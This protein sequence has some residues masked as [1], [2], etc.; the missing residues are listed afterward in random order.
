MVSG[1]QLFYAP[2]LGTADVPARISV[3]AS[4]I[5]HFPLP[6]SDLPYSST[7]GDQSTMV[8]AN[9]MSGYLFLFEQIIKTLKS[10][11]VPGV[12]PRS[13]I[14][15]EEL[16]R[17]DT[18]EDCKRSG[19][20]PDASRE[21]VHT[22]VWVLLDHEPAHQLQATME[23]TFTD[24][25]AE[26]NRRKGKRVQQ[27]ISKDNI[28][29]PDDLARALGF[30]RDTDEAFDYIMS[31]SVSNL[32]ETE[33]HLFW[34]LAPP[35]APLPAWV[36]PLQRNPR[37]QVRDG[38]EGI[39]T[40][41]WKSPYP[42]G[43][44]YFLYDFGLKPYCLTPNADVF[45][46]CYYFGIR[47]P[48]DLYRKAIE[49]SFSLCQDVD[50]DIA[51]YQSEDLVKGGS[52]F[53]APQQIKDPAYRRAVFDYGN[54]ADMATLRSEIATPFRVEEVRRYP[55][56]C[57]AL[58]HAVDV[59]S[60]VTSI[61][62]AEDFFDHFSLVADRLFGTKSVCIP[63]MYHNLRTQQ[64]RLNGLFDSMSEARAKCFRS[65]FIG[66]TPYMFENRLDFSWK[67]CF[68][69]NQAQAAV[70]SLVM[71]ASCM[72]VLGDCHLVHIQLNGLHQTGKSHAVRAV[73]ETL[74]EGVVHSQDYAS[75]LAATLGTQERGVL[76]QDETESPNS[77]NDLKVKIL[78][79]LTENGFVSSDR[80]I[81][82]PVT[83]QYEVQRS[84]TLG[85][86]FRL[87]T[88]NFAITDPALKSRYAEIQMPSTEISAFEPNVD[89][90]NDA[91]Y[92]IR[93]F[94]LSS[95]VVP[96]SLH[97]IGTFP[98]TT[99]VVQ[100]FRS[101]LK[102][103]DPLFPMPGVRDWKKIT[104]I[105]TSQ[106]LIR[107][108]L[109]F[110]A[111]RDPK[112]YAKQIGLNAW[113]SASDVVTAF[114]KFTSATNQQYRWTILQA[115]RTMVEI[116]Y[117]KDD[118]GKIISGSVVKCGGYYRLRQSAGLFSERNGKTL[119]SRFTQSVGASIAQIAPNARP[120]DSLIDRT[121][122]ELMNE[123]DEQGRPILIRLADDNN[124]MSMGLR[125]SDCCTV[126]TP[127]EI[128]QV[129]FFRNV[130]RGMSTRSD[131]GS[132]VSF[133]ERWYV[134]ASSLLEKMAD[135]LIDK[136]AFS[137]P[138]I[139]T[140]LEALFS[141]KTIFKSGAALN[142]QSGAKLAG[143]LAL[144][145]GAGIIGIKNV[146][147]AEYCLEARE[148]T[149]PSEIHKNR[150]KRLG[151]HMIGRLCVKISHTVPNQG[152]SDDTIKSILTEFVY[153][154][155]PEYKNKMIP[156]GAPV[157]A[158]KTTIPSITIPRSGLRESFE[159]NDHNHRD[160]TDDDFLSV[161]RD[162][163][164]NR[165][166]FFSGETA[167]IDLGGFENRIQHIHYCRLFPN[168]DPNLTSQLADRMGRPFPYNDPPDNRR[169]RRSESDDDDS[170]RG[171]QR[172][173]TQ[174]GGTIDDASD[175]EFS[176][177]L[178]L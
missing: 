129:K 11:T 138:V 63:E 37:V 147:I 24:L 143:G 97:A 175:D 106:M 86:L 64:S 81:Q 127:V 55:T 169:R 9:L 68:N 110:G 67:N 174:G 109:S 158:S 146:D 136:G 29:S 73:L 10:T 83:G 100:V 12:R 120:S 152:D 105:A 56:I 114:S 48:D 35:V 91:T 66:I 72:P 21:K 171:S 115:L 141:D 116:T 54:A 14:F 137:D 165:V 101:F 156:L 108:N 47:P 172:H 163:S 70:A 58:Q 160:E 93:H 46:Q 40:I 125:C 128:A 99:T 96:F 41:K 168:L 170:D 1:Q 161:G 43:C 167:R 84:M 140:E 123:T 34:Y 28:R 89:R 45:L 50:I 53:P 144:L 22:V 6:S 98:I 77:T 107:L 111:N 19:R 16:V 2:L 65:A 82:N 133:D 121:L 42:D 112:N 69:L 85:Y 59:R 52:P 88:G 164:S 124:K 36:A 80:V 102:A 38:G 151:S 90:V 20:Y 32:M 78:K 142:E 119:F 51:E 25:Q 79:S 118:N 61:D 13:K 87:E 26:D 75:N 27:P 31:D 130:Q 74:P 173:R 18:F 176:Q 95:T 155:A 60:M 4:L 71:V 33:G 92:S 39:D 153:L 145:Q 157:R 94:Y 104:T 162:T 132:R 62:Q 7:H 15:F 122:S 150:F 5:L 139:S 159:I 178:E 166:Q 8:S 44:T 134:L 23:A 30:L 113:L 126:L 49:D 148:D 17:Q 177:T 131:G 154:A 57:K 3:D 76:S 103:R 135:P 117:Q 149:V